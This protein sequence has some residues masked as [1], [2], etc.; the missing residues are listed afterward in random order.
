[1]RLDKFLTENKIGSRSEV[2]AFIK[3][4]FVT[5]NDEPAKRPE[6]TVDEEKDCIRYQG[7]QL[8][9]EPFVYY[10]LNKPI[11]VVSA[12]KDNLSTTVIDLLEKENRIDLFPVG[13][14]DKD[15][16]GLLLL[17]NDG[18]LAHELLSP[19]KH[20][21]KTYYAKVGGLITEI[22]I[23]QFE[24]G[25]SI[26]EDKD[27]LPARLE[28]LPS[29]DAQSAGQ[30]VSEVLVTITEGKFHQIKRMFFAVGMEVLYLK[31]LSMGKLVLDPDLPCGTYKKIAKTD[32]MD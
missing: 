24:K 29:A 18:Q 2:K 19:K 27:T 14:L 1:M 9:Y 22:E 11:G 28:V 23:S 25:L 3:K 16:E 8:F 4:G 31:R 17:T 6:Q 20:V 5:I 26:G 30:T 13:R 32:I 10:M 7:K 12:T 21:L 15:T